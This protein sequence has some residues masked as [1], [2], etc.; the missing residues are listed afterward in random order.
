MS[1]PDT[2]VILSI[3]L[4]DRES[5]LHFFSVDREASSL[6]IGGMKPYSFTTSI[7]S[8]GVSSFA[9]SAF[10]ASFSGVGF[11]MAKLLFA[12]TRARRAPGCR[13]YTGVAKRAAVS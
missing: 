11:A 10:S 2:L 8:F 5:F 13:G 1:M 9:S 6:A 12:A 7:S 4:V 3:V